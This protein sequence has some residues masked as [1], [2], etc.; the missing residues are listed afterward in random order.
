[1]KTAI[2]LASTQ[3]KVVVVVDDTDILVMLV[4]HWE[5]ES[6]N[7]YMMSEMTQTRSARI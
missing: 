5:P 3:Q 7:V 2:S 1:M 6:G 4:H